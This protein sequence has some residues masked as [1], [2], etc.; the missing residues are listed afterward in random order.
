MSIADFRTL[1]RILA[2][3]ELELVDEALAEVPAF[4]RDRKPAVSFDCTQ[5]AIH[6]WLMF[7]RPPD[8]E[9]LEL[10]PLSYDLVTG[11]YR[12]EE[13]IWSPPAS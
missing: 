11:R 1:R 3:H 7:G 2:E 5:E 10:R 4:I 12:D 6:R 13:S 9:W 8:V